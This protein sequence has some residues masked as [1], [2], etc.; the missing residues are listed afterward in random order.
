[1]RLLFA[2]GIYTGLRLGDAATLR[3]AEVDLR[4]RIIRR[5]P[6]KVA[7][8]NP[9]P[10][11]IPIHPSLGAMLTE[12]SSGELTE[13]VLPETAALYRGD[14]PALSN[15]IQKH[16]TAAVFAPSRKIRAGHKEKGR[17]RSRLSLLA[18]HFVSLCRESNAPLSVVEAIVGHSN[19]AMTRHYT[20][21]SEL[22]AANA[23]NALPTITG[24][25]ATLALPPADPLAVIKQNIHELADQLS[26]KNWKRIKA[27]LLQLA[28]G[29]L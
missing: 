19:P 27:E 7:R 22:A 3:W 24:T 4:R 14:A 12:V 26:G 18:A 17:C 16:F 29:Q 25:A 6:N 21:V 10:V 1:M 9:R 8:R 20:H 2:V 11:I 15:A 13:D 5:I 28:E 23:V